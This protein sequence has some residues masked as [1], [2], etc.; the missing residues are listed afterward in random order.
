MSGERGKTIKRAWEREEEQKREIEIR[1]IDYAMWQ[2]QLLSI[3]AQNLYVANGGKEKI[4][5]FEY[6]RPDRQK[7]KIVQTDNDFDIQLD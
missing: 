7:D 2:I 3:I 5:F 6:T 4:D 1:H